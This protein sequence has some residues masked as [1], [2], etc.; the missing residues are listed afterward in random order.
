LQPT[1]ETPRL[2]LR[3]FALSDAPEVERL[4]GERAIADTT[5]NIPH[6]Y[7]PGAA[8]EWIESH[9]PAY[10]AGTLH[11]FAVVERESGNLVGAVGLVVKAAHRRAE[12]GYWIGVA[13]WNRGYATEAARAALRYA[14]ETLG[15][16]RVQATH[17]L[18]NQASGRVMR[19]LGMT[20]EGCSRQYF[21][22]WDRFEDVER[23][24]ILRNQWPA[25]GAAVD[26]RLATPH[27]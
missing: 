18:R 20:H 16:N 7:P 11:S 9:A 10:R 19:K 27:Y 12:L 5:I 8:A 22:K 1:L 13:W 2:V 24:A 14:F 6:P 23:Y 21:L 4:A 26:S 17:F 15:L 25:P 3:P